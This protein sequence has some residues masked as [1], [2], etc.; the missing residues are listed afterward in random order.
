MSM[1]WSLSYTLASLSKHLPSGFEA[2]KGIKSLFPKGYKGSVRVL[3][4]YVFVSYQHFSVKDD[5]FDETYANAYV[6][7]DGT[8]RWFFSWYYWQTNPPKADYRPGAGFAFILSDKGSAH[9]FIDKTTPV[10]DWW[11]PP[12]NVSTNSQMSCSGG[13]DPWIAQNWPD[14]FKSG[15]KISFFDAAANPPSTYWPSVWTNAGFA[16]NAFINLE[17]GPA[18]CAA[19]LT[20]S[21]LFTYP[22]TPLSLSSPLGGLLPPLLTLIGLTLAKKA[23]KV[24]H[25]LTQGG[26]AFT[27]SPPQGS[28]KTM[29]LDF[30]A[31]DGSSNGSIKW[32]LSTG[33]IKATGTSSFNIHGV[34]GTLKYTVD[35][36]GGDNKAPP[37]GKVSCDVEAALPGN[38]KSSMKTT[39]INGMIESMHLVNTA[40]NGSVKTFILASTA[41]G[42]TVN[43]TGGLSNVAGAI[44]AQPVTL[45]SL[46]DPG[47]I[48]ITTFMRGL[49]NSGVWPGD[50]VNAESWE[51]EGW[52]DTESGQ[53]G[54][55]YTSKWGVG[56]T[57]E[58]GLAKYDI[59][60]NVDANGTPASY[61]IFGQIYNAPGSVTGNVQGVISCT[62]DLVANTTKCFV[63]MQ[64]PVNPSPDG[65][66][67]SGA[68]PDALASIN[69]TST[70]AADGTTSWQFQGGMANP[71][72]TS[73]TT[74]GNS[75]GVTSCGAADADGNQST[76]TITPYADGTSTITISTTDKDGNGTYETI[77][78]AADGNLVSDTTVPVGDGG[79][80]P[81]GTDDGNDDSGSSGSSA[82]SS[83]SGSSG[84][85]SGGG[86]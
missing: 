12:P 3:D 51:M 82:G 45:G 84:S 83:G 35:L 5:R 72:G 81:S 48:P 13:T 6:M 75:S 78:V 60:V 30:A 11:D 50:T 46:L 21:T 49:P 54:A 29:G 42:I 19:T 23:D 43:G 15:A 64:Y 86:T 7:A 26:I 4:Q 59:S 79:G 77:N 24:A 38:A 37:V 25:T 85:E 40:S 22:N 28:A 69:L 67:A 20:G 55:T 63:D 47:T 53:E 36:A 61:S 66:T 68:T 16:N 65:D 58:D 14:L 62:V 56:A 57:P 74:S 39:S 31:A 44:A 2:K 70:R 1:I 52:T 71:D 9:V 34:T 33:A 18:A 32:T 73:S 8:G 80:S 41:A 27:F 76:S 17:G 10:Y